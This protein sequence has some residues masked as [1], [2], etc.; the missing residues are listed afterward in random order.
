MTLNYHYR[1]SKT[2][3]SPKYFDILTSSIHDFLNCLPLVEETG[4]VDLVKFQGIVIVIKHR[5][6]LRE[7]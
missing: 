4:I 2:H 3:S 5:R 6:A 1:N 7:K